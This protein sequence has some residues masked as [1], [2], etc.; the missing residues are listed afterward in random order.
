ML[1]LR[2]HSNALD[3]R[4][5]L[6]FVFTPFLLPAQT[7]LEQIWDIPVE[8]FDGNSLKFPWIGGLGAS[9]FSEMDFD[10]DGKMDLL[11]FDRSGNKIKTFLNQG[12]QG[13]EN[14]IHA[15]EFEG[16]FPE[17]LER[18][19]LTGDINCDGTNDIFTGTGDKIKVFLSDFNG[20]EWSFNEQGNIQADGEEIFLDGRNL[21]AIKD[22]DGDG[23]LDILLLNAQG[24]GLHFL[25]LSVEEGEG[26][27]TLSYTLAS[28]CWG[29]F[30]Y[31][32]F[33]PG[34]DL[35]LNCVR[36]NN[37]SAYHGGFSLTLHDWDNDDDL[38]LFIGDATLSNIAYLENGGEDIFTAQ[39]SLFPFATE[40][41]DLRFPGVYP[42]DVDN[43][44]NKELI[45]G[46]HEV[47]ST[48][49]QHILLIDESGN[50]LNDR[51]LL[52]EMLDAGKG[53]FPSLVD[54]D[55]DGDQDLLIAPEETRYADGT[56]SK[57]ILYQN[58]GSDNQPYFRETDQDFL[59]LSSLDQPALDL[60]FLDG[61]NDGDLDLF[62]GTFNQ[63]I[64]YYSNQGNGIF[65]AETQGGM[66]VQTFLMNISFTDLDGNGSKELLLGKYNGTVDV[67]QTDF[68]G[69]SPQ[70]SLQE[71]GLCDIQVWDG[72]NPGRANI[73]CLD[74]PE[75]TSL[76]IGNAQ[77]E[78][79]RI[80]YENGDCSTETTITQAGWNA[81]CHTW[82]SPA[83]TA[84]LVG[85]L[86]GG[87]EWFQAENPN[88]VSLP[89]ITDE[90]AF[91]PYPNPA[92][93][94]DLIQWE[95]TGFFHSG[96]TVRMYSSEG[97]Q[98]LEVPFEKGQLNLNAL[99]SGTYLMTK[100][101][102]SHIIYSQ[103][104][105]IH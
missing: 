85:N 20:S 7:P 97:K 26:C 48:S 41:V 100:E 67:Y 45:V 77:G 75:N 30:E 32:G 70:F 47:L 101:N 51:F 3:I 57:A 22:M 28:D 71:S 87:L 44:G 36:L 91:L 27:H 23:D 11:V 4:P 56:Y 66:E 33:D 88:S 90:K 76:F 102:G 69:N 52:D 18:W 83:G 5:F 103:K 98:I 46:T 55:N 72:T 53:S 6:I 84:L 65:Q 94:Q 105:I 39:D 1:N 92:T 24:R 99:P 34:A 31:A 58:I 54:Y 43:D 12:A 49:N 93:K 9:V 64:R 17:N 19:V 74:T 38:D 42:I 96:T 89:E 15:P 35:E 61:D 21:P 14:Y 8:N 62:L 81:T 79:I 59:N 68:S 40:S 82:E 29:D 37:R 86:S 60:E 95:T 73:S 2:K 80:E 13:E 25:N 16:I 104:I 63:G 50:R 10:Q 78:I